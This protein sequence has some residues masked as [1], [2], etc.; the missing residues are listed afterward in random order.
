MAVFD[1]SILC[2]IVVTLLTCRMVSHTGVLVASNATLLGLSVDDKI[3]VKRST[4]YLC[5]MKHVNPFFF[6]KLWCSV[7]TSVLATWH[8]I[9][10]ERPCVQYFF[11]TISW[12]ADLPYRER[13][14]NARESV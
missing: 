12:N 13:K 5:K 14:P 4:C 7:T 3:F 10:M 1:A 11:W 8:S 9:D 6:T 2:A